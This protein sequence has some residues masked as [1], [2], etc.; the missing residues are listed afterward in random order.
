MKQH[1]H[2][3]QL[4]LLFRY[5]PSVP[6]TGYRHAP[7][8]YVVF[9][10]NH[11]R[12]SQLSRGATEA[13]KAA[14]VRDLPFVSSD[15]VAQVEVRALPDAA[16]ESRVRSEQVTRFMSRDRQTGATF[17]P[18][19]LSLETT[20]YS[21]WL[22]L[23]GLAERVLTVLMDVAPVDGVDRIG[24]RYIDELRVPASGAP[25]WSRWVP[26]ELLPP[27]L[28][29]DLRPA[30][31]QS[32]IQYA[33]PDPHTLLA[34]RYGAVEGPSSVGNGPIARP[35]MPE[36]GH[37]FLLDTD[38]GWAPR[39][40]EIVPELEVTDVLAKADDLHSHVKRLFEA[41][42]TDTIREEVLDAE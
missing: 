12:T 27:K 8:V 30:Q 17:G 11:P 20:N 24:L 38:A 41:S 25:D 33:T 18:D 42:L 6:S 35:E 15:Q 5:S 3:C 37:Y 21:G 36:P 7:L 19:S 1:L 9:Q 10:V 23:R 13:M 2:G 4:W 16:P 34:L 29:D 22:A 40:G 39:P 14:L 31:Q 32:T 28:V 26:S